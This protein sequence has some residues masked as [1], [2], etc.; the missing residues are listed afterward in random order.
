MVDK[1]VEL[2]NNRK[3]VI[4]DSKELNNT[5]YYYGLRL[6]KS[7]EPT[8]N[9]LFFEETT[10]GN[11]IYLAPVEDEKIRSTLLTAFTI[12]YLDNVYDIGGIKE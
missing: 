7:E 1:I 4:L 10:V 8:N 6:D 3:Y 2:E 11:D 5:K 9:Y 12:N